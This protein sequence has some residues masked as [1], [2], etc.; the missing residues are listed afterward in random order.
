MLFVICYL[1]FVLCCWGWLLATVPFERLEIYRLAER[2]SDE[3]WGVVLP[4]DSFAKE[5]VGRQLVRAVDSIGA[6]I[7][8]GSG[9]GSFQD[10][11]RFV[12]I[13][14]GSLNET[15]HWLRR[16]F[17]RGLLTKSQI[18]SLK[19]L[20]DELAPRLNA[21]LNSITRNITKEQPTANKQ[22]ITNNQ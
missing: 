3:I 5:T 17:T 9:R 4:W 13:A 20:L 7:A 15:K 19:P 14:R 22:P 6:N 10:N 16:A 18:A 2:L 21:Y 8:E 1:L 12:R 11:R